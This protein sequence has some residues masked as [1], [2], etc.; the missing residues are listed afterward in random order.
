MNNPNPKFQLNL[1]ETNS[2][3]FTLTIEGST[4]NADTSKPEF[5]FVL[6]ENGNAR[7]WLYPMTKDEDGDVVVQIPSEGMFSEKKSYTGQ[8]EV[9]LDNHYFTPT[10]I[11]IEFTRPLKV[12]AAISIKKSNIYKEQTAT[13]SNEKKPTVRAIIQK[14]VVAQP[15]I[16]KLNVA[17][18]T[19]H[20]KRSWNDL[21]KEE[22]EKIK[23]I[24][25]ERKVTQLRKAKLDEVKKGKETKELAHRKTLVDKKVEKSLKDRLKN[26]MSDS[27]LDE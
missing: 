27:L 24:L 16:V 6:S 8:V 19:Q 18:A 23:N 1:N 10:T 22:Q 20:K 4:T 11:D 5:R 2:L 26:L 14:K 21:T 3:G 15:N 9:I 17:G 13:K 7:S 12:E 25:R